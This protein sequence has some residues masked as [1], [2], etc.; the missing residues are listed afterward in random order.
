[1]GRHP[2][3]H[4]E[5]QRT[6]RL[7]KRDHSVPQVRSEPLVSRASPGHPRKAGGLDRRR[8]V[9]RSRDHGPNRGDARG[10]DRTFAATRVGHFPDQSGVPRL[11][12][13]S[14]LT[15]ILRVLLAWALATAGARAWDPAGHMLV[16]EIAWDH[17]HPAAR[18][19]V[20]ES[21]QRLETTYNANQAYHFVTAG[22]WM[23][24]LRS[25]QGYPWAAWHY[26]TIP[27]SVDGKA[28]SLPAAPHVVWAIEQSVRTLKEGDPESKDAA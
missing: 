15:V 3:R 21:A 10:G 6:G 25:K 4:F 13:S 1:M 26:V 12:N 9:R 2:R 28:F 27:W 22:C 18:A 5:H 16:S 11:Q 23:D 14:A 24:D 20:H 7:R 8:A 17:T 19:R